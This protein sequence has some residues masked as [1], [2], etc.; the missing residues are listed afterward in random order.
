MM[1]FT[2]N[3]LATAVSIA[4][5][6]LA[7][8][9][10]AQT[11]ATKT[12]E[13]IAK[14]EAEA[15]AKAAADKKAGTAQQVERIVVTSGKRA[16]AA[17]KVPY[18]VSALS[19]ETMR[20]ENITDVKKLIQQ[21]VAINA[22]Q[23]SARFA[24]SVT[25]RGLNVSPVSANNLEQ[26]VKTTIAY[27]LD[28]TPLPSIGFRIKDVSRVETLLGPQG[29]LYGAGSLGGTIR[30]ITN[31]P[32]LDK[33]EG[34]ISTGLY[35]TKGGG[36]SNDT[37]VMF[38]FPMGEN[39]ALRGSYAHLDEKGY[40]DRVSNPPWRVGN[41]AWVT[42]PDPTRNRYEDDD[43]Q[44]VDGGRL[45]LL[46]KVN[47]DV[48]V[49]VSHA[50]QR[51][52]ANGTTGTSLL[53]CDVANSRTPAET[54]ASWRRARRNDCAAL[55]AGPE[56][57]TFFSPLLTPFS[58]GQDVVVSRY[59]EFAIRNF[60]MDSVELDVDLGFARLASSTSQFTDARVGQADY[61]SQGHVFYFGFGD[62]G[63][64]ID[65]GRS[66]FI[67]YNNAYKGFSHETR[68]VSKNDGPLNW[69][70]GLYYTDQDKS[71]R[72]SEML[73]GLDAFNRLNRAS[74][75]GIKDEGYFENLANKYS[76]TAVF[77]EV[78]YKVTPK[79]TT[80]VGARAFQY[81][82]TAIARIVD[83]AAG[84]V[85]SDYTRGGGRK[86][87]S[88]FKL[89]TS[90]QFADDLLGYAT[91]SQGFRRGGTNGFKD[92]GKNIVTAEN[93]GY[94]PDST[95]NFEL[96]LKGYAL[97]RMLYAEAAVYQIDWKNVQTY[98]NQSVEGF[99]VNGTANGPDARSRGFE[100]STRYKL[101][102]SWQATYST[103]TSQAEWTGTRENC[104][105]VGNVKDECRLWSKGGKLGGSPKWKH[106]FGA[107]FNTSLDNGM[108][109]WASLSGRYTGPIAIDR[110]DSPTESVRQRP[111]YTL[112]NANS[113]ISF[114]NWDANFWIQNLANKRA[115]V[116]AQ[117]QGIMGARLTFATPRTMGVNVT[118]YFK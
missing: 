50:E 35:Q 44:K 108:Y 22:P 96:G 69:I 98:R 10:F 67:T 94:E 97:N 68:L 21:S 58:V 88:Y 71:L 39:F 66:A 77:G 19:E 40:T 90:Y 85:D 72:F 37:D 38:N 45:A 93:A 8:P 33:T 111:A 11:A 81:K 117:E 48:S 42:Q 3:P 49:T 24:D 52:N 82:D 13:M 91:F 118:Y 75:G 101:N 76:E 115:E 64:K 87:K 61:A 41:F 29:T 63:G 73:P 116:S 31:K 56:T 15:K 23:N 78:N 2:K 109:L 89:N 57:R 51:Q 112:L 53:P 7:M 43:W 28:E 105:Y 102:D 17:Y 26:F 59:P 80:T 4:L 114:G 46:W 30:Y 47:N 27:Y 70:A 106:N 32:K 36:I 55:A 100:L 54:E 95:N 9:A 60:K 107:R 5:L 20:E 74:V 92:Q 103:T 6:T 18:N 14:E 16:E 62:L 79:W 86:S 65:S 113:G 104:L 83:Y 110:A 34:R 25:V 99:P 1:K 12:P 84:F